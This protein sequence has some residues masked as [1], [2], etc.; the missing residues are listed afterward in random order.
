MNQEDGLLP[1]LYP[2]IPR[3]SI[4]IPMVKPTS[5]NIIILL[6]LYLPHPKLLIQ[7]HHM[8][9]HTRPL[10]LPLELPLQVLEWQ[11]NLTTLILYYQA[12]EEHRE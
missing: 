1:L 11:T 10:H 6:P 4:P 8:E 5:K 9:V 7:C 3:F 12:Q 2:E